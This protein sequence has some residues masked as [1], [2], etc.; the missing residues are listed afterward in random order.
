MVGKRSVLALA[1]LLAIPCAAIAG[2]AEFTPI[3]SLGDVLI[4]REKLPHGWTLLEKRLVRDQHDVNLLA[5]VDIASKS[6]GVTVIE[7]ACQPLTVAEQS[8]NVD[9]FSVKGGQGAETLFGILEGWAN[10]GTPGDIQWGCVRW[11]NIIMV[12]STSDTKIQ[13][14]VRSAYLSRLLEVLDAKAAGFLKQ[15]QAVRALE[16]YKFLGTRLKDLPHAYQAWGGLFQYQVKDYPKAIVHYERAA[17]EGGE[18][19]FT[20]EEQWHIQEGIGLCAGM[21]KD[22]R[23]A[24]AAFLKSLAVARKLPDK[25][26][27][28]SSNYNLACAYA[29]QGVPDKMYPYLEE[30]LKLGRKYAAQA[31]EDPSFAKYVQQPRFK[32]LIGKY[33]K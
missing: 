11:G 7:K 29:E 33:S 21:S 8:F 19:A 27:L 14:E 22:A 15:G 10:P 1:A 6:F 13:Q 23:K 31:S 4:P 26:W 12:V 24:E 18:T 17:K 3:T 32:V 16:C 5:T 2:E 28:G 20:L 25:Q 30:A 9:F